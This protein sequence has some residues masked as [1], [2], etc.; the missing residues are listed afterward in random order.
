MSYL[1]ALASKKIAVVGAGV[2]GSAVLDFLVTRGI[3]ADIFDEKLVG[4]SQAVETVYDLAIVSPGWRGD[5]PILV[6]LRSTGCEL[7]SEIDFS[8]LVKEEVAPN[9][10]WI[11]LT[12]T[13]GKTTTIQMMQSIFDNS[14]KSGISCGN[15]G[16]PVISVLASGEHFDFLALELSSFQLEWS[17][18]PVFEA[19]ALL[20]IAPDHIDW[21]GSFD[22]YA[23]AKLK[24]LE[25]GKIAIINGEDSE[26]VLRAT[27]WSG[28]KVFYYLDTP[29]A[30]EIGL[31]ENLLIDRA[32][33]ESPTH[34]T[35]FAQLSD[36]R[37]TV[38]HNVSNAMAAAG[39]ALAIGISHEEIRSGLQNFT[40]DRHRLELVLEKDGI[41]WVNDSKATNPHAAAAALLAHLSSIWI[42]GGLAKGAEMG[43]LIERCA[44]RIKSAILIGQ[45]APII[46]SALS[47]YAPSI[48]YFI[49]P[50]SG[51]SKELM[52]SV[53]LKA[54]EM[55]SAGD[56]VLL[57]PA[58]ASMDQFNDYAD[59]GEKFVETVREL[60][61]R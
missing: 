25:A 36:I 54:K 41:S 4:A 28:K 51:D 58:C 15:V 32:F 59:R 37:P 13:N 61:G 48:P 16:E 22:A 34:A 57:A 23:L 35:E 20:N 10:K 42:A 26:S 45:D 5:H 31:V 1:V 39:L 47:R 6:A 60:V 53:V 24:L 12:G 46:A 38:P 11:A 9:Q 44:L 19:V 3:D 21:H 8:W 50:F 52:R 56:T 2:T 43:P 33:T 30:G 7:I 27:S 40:P 18:L 49:M 55:A 29:Q 14:S 17:N